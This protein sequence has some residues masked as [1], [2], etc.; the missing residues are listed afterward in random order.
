MANENGA[1]TRQGKTFLR[2]HR[3]AWKCSDLN[4][5]Q[6]CERPAQGVR[7][8]AGEVQSRAAAARTQAALP[9][10]RPKSAL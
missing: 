8:L 7:Q 5:R 10:P 2:A 6:Y 4:E 3:E 9:P 1:W